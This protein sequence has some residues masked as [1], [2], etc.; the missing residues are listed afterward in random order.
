M[1][2]WTLT[3]DMENWERAISS[4]VWGVR[5]GRKNLWD[6]LEV[7][8]MLFFY[9]KKPVSGIVGTGRVIRKFEQKTPFWADEVRENKVIYPYRFEFKID[10]I[11][12][13]TRW[14]DDAVKIQDLGVGVIGGMN[15]LTNEDTV[16]SLITR[17]DKS[18]NTTLSLRPEEGLEKPEKAKPVNLHDEIKQ[19]LKEIGEIEGWLSEIEYRTSGYQFDVVWRKANVS[20]AVPRYVFEVQ[21]GGD[22][23]HALTNLKHAFDLWEPK[24]FLIAQEEDIQKAN[25]LMEG[26]F[27][28]IRGN[29]KLIQI[30]KIKELHEI[31][32]KDFKLKSEIGIV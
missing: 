21:I 8:D 23:K 15:P 2:F 17:L 30:E 6:R 12:P 14:R 29:L 18:W 32:I 11:I 31:Q 26:A 28:E 1:R 16:K 24:L 9:I 20:G 10:Y 19:K 13:Q 22:I 25:E 7:G 27:H 3:G 4:S 5:E